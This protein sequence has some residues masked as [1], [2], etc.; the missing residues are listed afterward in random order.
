MNQMKLKH[1]IILTLLLVLLSCQSSVKVK[2]S[3][4]CQSCIVTDTIFSKNLNEN[5][6]ISIYLPKGYT[7]NKTYPVVYCTDGQTVVDSYKIEIDSVIS[8]HTVPEFIMI[9]VH[10]NENKVKNSEFD[11][12][13]FEY[14][15][16]WADEHD[17]LLNLRFS[18]HHKFFSQEVITHVEQKYSVSRNS[19][20][21][22]FYGTSNGA[23]YGVTLGA[24]NPT[25]FEN[26]ICFSMAGGN[27]KKLDLSESNYPCYYLSYG[28]K[29]PFPLVI[30]I[31]EFE[32]FL[33]K[34]NYDH[35]FWIYNGGHDRLMWKKEFFKTLTKV[36]N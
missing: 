1:N 14:I 34:N 5:R 16:G 24:N 30:A 3:I 20:D 26:Y 36:L 17:S 9:G 31:N 18:N 4:A 29:E 25:L 33:T 11:Y 32:K 22:V 21:K 27:Y 35:K 23:G 6:L 2:T 13:N 8:R 19:K 28:N 12:R 10:S 15:K 7:K